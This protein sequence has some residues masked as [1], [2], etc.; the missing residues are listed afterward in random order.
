MCGPLINTI[1][2]ATPAAP[3][4][5]PKP[6][7][8]RSSAGGAFTGGRGEL[9]IAL[10]CFVPLDAY[11][12][13]RRS[14]SK[15]NGQM[16]NIRTPRESFHHTANKIRIGRPSPGSARADIPNNLI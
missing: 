16:T 12:E 11:C 4:Q 13:R 8:G 3:Y 15:T 9:V 7:A 6:P 5:R 1:A 2:S 14:F 10:M